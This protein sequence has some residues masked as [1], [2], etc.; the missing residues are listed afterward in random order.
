MSNL[1]WYVYLIGFISFIIGIFFYYQ[2]RI[3]NLTESQK[4]DA[5]LGW[6]TLKYTPSNSVTFT[7]DGQ[8]VSI[9]CGQQNRVDCIHLAGKKAFKWRKENDYTN[10]G[11]V[12]NP[13][14]SAKLQRAHENH[15]DLL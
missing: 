3:E 10:D 7:K 12:I 2:K 5:I 1:Q 11:F 8:V 13:Y 4:K 15:T 14:E 9:G 6:I